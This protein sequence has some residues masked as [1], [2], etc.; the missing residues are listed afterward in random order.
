MAMPRHYFQLYAYDELGIWITLAVLPNLFSS[1]GGF[2]K[3]YERSSICSWRN[4]FWAF[5]SLLLKFGGKYYFIAGEASGDLGRFQSDCCVKTK[6]CN[7]RISSL[8]WGQNA[9][10][11]SANRKT[12]QISRFYG[13]LGGGQNPENNSFLYCLVKKIFSHSNL[14]LNPYRLPGF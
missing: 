11:G 2:K 10:S 14:M 9:K 13:I 8:G 6:R 12:L 5:L 3:E 1:G 4:H 7:I